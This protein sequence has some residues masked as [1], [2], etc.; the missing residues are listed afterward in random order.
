MFDVHQNYYTEGGEIDERKV[1]AYIDGLMED[2][3]HSP[4][5]QPLVGT[6]EGIGWAATMMEFSFNYLGHSPAQM[7][8]PDFNEVVFD[9]FPRKLSVEPEHAPAMIRGQQLGERP[10]VLRPHLRLATRDKNRRRQVPPTLELPGNMDE[11][12]ARLDR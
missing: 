11:S 12:S 8:L 3:A 10:G 4:E 6:E 5:A 7:S 1:Q 9:L 2:F